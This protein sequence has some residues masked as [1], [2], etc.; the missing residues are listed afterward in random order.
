MIKNRKP[1]IIIMITSMML[2]LGGCQLAVEEGTENTVEDRLIGTLITTGSLNPV[3]M[4]NEIM[5]EMFE[6]MEDGEF[7]MDEFLEME[8]G[9]VI[10]TPSYEEKRYVFEGVKGYSMFN[11]TMHEKEPDQT[12]STSVADDGISDVSTHITSG[13]TDKIEMKGTIYFSQKT[14]ERVWY[15]NPVYQ[16]ENGVVY[17]I[18]GTGFG[19]E[20][21]L[22]EGTEGST[23]IEQALNVT[24]NGT[25]KSF[26][27]YI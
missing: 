25:T 12:Y 13:D 22:G 15:M 3:D 11:A 21:E 14:G 16:K 4:N 9:V 17:A 1:W 2:I 19:M 8:G 26:E 20:G 24:A 23:N 7:M 10:A 18:P 6:E 5:P 27:S